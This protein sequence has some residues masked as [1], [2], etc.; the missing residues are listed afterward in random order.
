MEEV[1]TIF[2]AGLPTDAHPRELE[3][4]MRFLPGYE[5]IKLAGKG[6]GGGKGGMS[7]FVKFM[8]ADMAAAAMHVLNNNPFDLQYPTEVMRVELAR[9]DMKTPVAPVLRTS[10]PLV[11][12]YGQG[13]QIQTPTALNM[14]FRPLSAAAGYTTPLAGGD[15]AA[16]RQRLGE[17]TP[18]Q[19]DTLAVFGALERGYSEAQLEEY[20][21][22]FNG[23]V[24]FKSN[25]RVGGG[26]V[27]FQTPWQAQEA[28][29]AAEESGLEIKMA[30]ASMHHEAVVRGHE[31]SFN[32]AGHPPVNAGK[33]PALPAKGGKGGC[34]SEGGVDTLI[35]Q[36]VIEKGWTVQSLMEGL[37]SIPGFVQ[38]KANERVGGGFA[39]FLTPEQAMAALSVVSDIGIDAQ[40]ARTSMG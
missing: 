33:G 24:C 1:S 13:L 27:K 12:A 11:Q 22:H 31:D 20:F 40:I 29:M 16:K 28:L 32:A 17:T 9:Q 38:F 14:G 7:M 10:T 4:T 18:D 6:S 3:N 5:G 35:L 15:P 39:K 37:Q 8:T 36:G 25:R 21:G 23:F 26:F 30:K 34:G 19:V 2:V